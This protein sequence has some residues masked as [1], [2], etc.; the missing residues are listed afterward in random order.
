MLDRTVTTT[1]DRETCTGCGEC[2]KVCPHETIS[3]VD[4]KASITGDQSLTCD[5]CRAACTSGSITVKGID[6][7]LSSFQSFEAETKWLP[8]GK[9]DIKNLVNL[10]QSRRSCRNYKNKP[11]EM[12]LLEDLVKIGITAPSGSNCQMWSF[13]ILKDRNSVEAFGKRV[14]KFFEDINRMAEKGWLRVLLKILGKPELSNYY[15]NYY[16]RM[17]EG[18][19]DWDKNGKDRLFHGAPAAILVASRED[20]S[21]PAED[22]LLASQNILLAAH[23]MGLGACL[24][25]FA[26]TAMKKDRKICDAIGLPKDETVYAVIA[27]GYPAEK[28]KKVTGR[29]PAPVRIIDQKI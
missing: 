14:K 25:G 12:A 28:Y 21:C 2:I 8:Y 7:S 22:A 15:L 20:A 5:H 11:V 23:A 13:N 16:E 4:G 10:M 29:K 19:D 1:I 24:V 6:E 26:V 17:K 27:V 3:L 9:F 18:L